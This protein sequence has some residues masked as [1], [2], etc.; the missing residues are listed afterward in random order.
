VQLLAGGLH[1]AD[2]LRYGVDDSSKF[3]FGFLDLLGGRCQRC[4]RSFSLNRDHRHVA[5]ALD[6]L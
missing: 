1:N 3:S 6:K 2:E 5:G 4:P